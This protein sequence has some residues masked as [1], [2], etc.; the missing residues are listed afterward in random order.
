[1]PV[2]VLFF[3]VWSLSLV[4]WMSQFSCSHCNITLPAWRRRAQSRIHPLDCRKCHKFNFGSFSGAPSSEHRSEQIQ[5]TLSE[6]EYISAQKLSVVHISSPLIFLNTVHNLFVESCNQPCYIFYSPGGSIR[7][8]WL[9]QSGTL[10]FLNGY[11]IRPG[12]E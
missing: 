1:M 5:H 3:G 6:V 12:L 2:S 4:V 7:S 10:F 8:G 9:T 11:P